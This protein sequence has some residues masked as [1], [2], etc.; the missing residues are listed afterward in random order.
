MICVRDGYV[1][2]CSATLPSMEIPG[3][4]TAVYNCFLFLPLFLQKQTEVENYGGHLFS[5][6][7]S[8][9]G[10]TVMM[11]VVCSARLSVKRHRESDGM[12]GEATDIVSK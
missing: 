10:N 8:D 1:V 2:V 7:S 9:K 6:V 3:L 4:F 5:P 12:E 11:W